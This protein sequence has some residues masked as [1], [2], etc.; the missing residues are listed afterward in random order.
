MLEKLRMRF[1]SG[2]IFHKA[3]FFYVANYIFRMLS[4]FD[5]VFPHSEFYCFHL[6]K[7]I[8]LKVALTSLY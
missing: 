2:S 3:L 4:L 6:Y 5:Q 1:T 8:R 7:H